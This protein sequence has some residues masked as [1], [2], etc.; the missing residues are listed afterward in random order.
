MSKIKVAADSVPS[1]GSLP[2][3]QVS[4]FGFSSVHLWEGGRERET[5]RETEKQTERDKERQR[6]RQKEI[7]L[8]LKRPLIPYEGPTTMASSNPS[9]LP[10]PL[11]QCHRTGDCGYTYGFSGRQK[12]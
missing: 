7:P 12:Y 9:C 6:E 3:L 4:V 8:L 11:L 5:E 10:K 1:E 2:G